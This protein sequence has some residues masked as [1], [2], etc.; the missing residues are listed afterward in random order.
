MSEKGEGSCEGNGE[1][2]TCGV[3]DPVGADG[4]GVNE[5]PLEKSPPSTKACSWLF[6]LSV[7]VVSVEGSGV[8]VRAV[9]G[10]GEG[11]GSGFGIGVE[12]SVGVYGCSVS[13]G[14]DWLNVSPSIIEV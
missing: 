12:D 7:F 14:E 5:S 13:A 2:T 3:G 4:D 11:T 8:G 6:G 1:G 9:E 10:T